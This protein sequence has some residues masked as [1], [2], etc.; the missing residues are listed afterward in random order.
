M[1]TTAADSG[2]NQSMGDGAQRAMKRVGHALERPIVGAGV[3]GGL[4]AA[5]AGA[6]GPSEAAIGAAAALIAYR[7]LN[8][9]LRR[10]SSPDD[11]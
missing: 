1:N 5:A 6:W 4:V 3:V 11:H 10:E 7:M 2:E 9:R 8:K